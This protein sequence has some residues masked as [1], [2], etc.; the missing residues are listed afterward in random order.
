MGFQ[1]KT[2]EGVYTRNY[3]DTVVRGF[4]TKPK[5]KQSSG[6]AGKYT[7]NPNVSKYFQMY[8]RGK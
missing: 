2:G 5:K 7:K 4:T 1:P 6:G 8:C 3:Y